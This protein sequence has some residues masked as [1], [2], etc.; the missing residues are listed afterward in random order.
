MKVALACMCFRDL[1]AGI[2]A[3]N[4]HAVYTILLFLWIKKDVE[5]SELHWWP[6]ALHFCSVIVAGF[7]NRVTGHRGRSLE[8]DALLCQHRLRGLEPKGWAPR[9]KGTCLIYPCKQ[10]T[11]VYGY[12]LFHWLLYSQCYVT[13][14]TSSFLKFVSCHTA[15][16]SP[17]RNVWSSFLAKSPAIKY[18]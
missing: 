13:L 1:T 2:F 5:I 14:L 3:Q 11:E 7:W 4:C 16:S 18:L 17:L 9:T 12:V 8:S 15:P 10:V 6:Q